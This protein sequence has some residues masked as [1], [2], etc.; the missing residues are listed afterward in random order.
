MGWPAAGW[1]AS[2][3]VGQG[4]ARWA[5]PHR[6]T[7]AARSRSDLRRSLAEIRAQASRRSSGGPDISD[8]GVASKYSQAPEAPE[9]QVHLPR[10][11]RTCH[12]LVNRLESQHDRATASVGCVQ[13]WT[14]GVDRPGTGQCRDRPKRHHRFSTTARI[15]IG[16]DKLGDD[17]APRGQRI[18]LPGRHR[19]PCV[20]AVIN[21]GEIDTDE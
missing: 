16:G 13:A 7:T 4:A 2:T 1:L 8:D 12:N 21:L 15:G 20:A 9:R 3:V 18:V 10:F 14:T 17:L 19:A 6:G 5:L 11:N